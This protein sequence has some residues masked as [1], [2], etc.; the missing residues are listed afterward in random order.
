MKARGYG[1][2]AIKGFL[3]RIFRDLETYQGH[4]IEYA[5]AIESS[6]SG[7]RHPHLLLGSLS[8]LAPAELE[9]VFREH[10][11]GK[12][13]VEVWDRSKENGYMFKSLDRPTRPGED[14]CWETSA[15]WNKVCRN[16]MK[17]C[18][19]HLAILAGADG[20]LP[21]A[22]TQDEVDSA[23]LQSLP[24]LHSRA[25]AHARRRSQR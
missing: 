16:R 1:D 7:W 9:A 24:P 2:G 19:K 23:Q 13:N 3:R 15:V 20:S 17:L 10:R 22:C 21:S 25:Q 6:D 8:R 18:R 4:K 11:F 12:I 5:Y 14:Y